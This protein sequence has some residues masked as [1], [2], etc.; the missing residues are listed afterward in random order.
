MS[1]TP[2]RNAESDHLNLSMQVSKGCWQLAGLQKEIM[3]A[4]E[5]SKLAM[6]SAALLA[7]LGRHEN[8]VQ[9][10]TSISSQASV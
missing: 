10:C 7:Y 1:P 3:T 5:A 6:Q 8:R 2:C 4:F 9:P